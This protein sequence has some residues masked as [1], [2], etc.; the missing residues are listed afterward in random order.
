M[1]GVLSVFHNLVMD[2]L[3]ASRMWV[4]TSLS[5][6]GSSSMVRFRRASPGVGGMEY[7]GVLRHL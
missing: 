7:V 5:D 4:V 1:E 2:S 3:A 6:K